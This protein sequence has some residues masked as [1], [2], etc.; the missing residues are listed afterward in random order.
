LMKKQMDTMIFYSHQVW[1]CDGM[2]ADFPN[3]P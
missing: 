2:E 1:S 3:K